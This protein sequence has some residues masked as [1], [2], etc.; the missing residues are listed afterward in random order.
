[1]S[2]FDFGDFAAVAN[3]NQAI[4]QGAAA[5]RHHRQQ[6]QELERQTRELQS[7]NRIDADR[8]TIERQRLEIE[9]KRLEAEETER[10]LQKMQA[11]KIKQV[12]MLLADTI[13]SFDQLKKLR[14]AP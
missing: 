8:A 4:K 3:H 11:E 2:G 7:K 6:L 1:M 10:Q 9:K 12:R 5:A 13:T 14:P